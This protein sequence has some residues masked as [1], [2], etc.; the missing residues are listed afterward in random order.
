[1]VNRLILVLRGSNPKFTEGKGDTETE[2]SS[3]IGTGCNGVLCLCIRYIS[4]SAGYLFKVCCC[5][6]YVRET[7]IVRFM[8]NK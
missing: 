3:A 8:V 1:M 4:E 7:G 6:V 2:L 5:F